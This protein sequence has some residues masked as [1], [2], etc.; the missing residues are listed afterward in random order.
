MHALVVLLSYRTSVSE[1]LDDRDHYWLGSALRGVTFL[2]VKGRHQPLSW[3]WNCMK[4]PKPGPQTTCFFSTTKHVKM[5]GSHNRFPTWDVLNSKCLVDAPVGEIEGFAVPQ[6]RPLKWWVFPQGWFF[7]S[8]NFFQ[9]FW[10]IFLNFF[11]QISEDWTERW[12]TTWC[13]KYGS[14]TG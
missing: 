13:L 2:E 3:N 10:V 5:R 12:P 6:L 8:R 14:L 7:K 11:L 4:P 1:N 9:V